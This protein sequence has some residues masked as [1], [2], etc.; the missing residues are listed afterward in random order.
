MR[1]M[2]PEP[3][4]QSEVNQKERNKERVLTHIYGI[5]T[6]GTDERICR[7]AVETQTQGTDLTQWGEERAG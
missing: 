4:I 1:W 7:A 2:I 5:Q 6:D 3:I